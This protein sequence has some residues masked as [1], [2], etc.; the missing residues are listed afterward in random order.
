M[1]WL[2]E[3]PRNYGIGHVVQTVP[4]LSRGKISTTRF[5]CVEKLCKIQNIFFC[6]LAHM[7][8]EGNHQLILFRITNYNELCFIP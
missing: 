3:L 7:V 8:N 6:F 5:I 1:P 4:C 2:P